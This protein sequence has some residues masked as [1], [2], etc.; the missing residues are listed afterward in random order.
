ML[1]CHANKLLLL[2]LLNLMVFD[3]ILL[4]R[5]HTCESYYTRGRHSN[6]DCFYLAQ[7]YFK[8]PRQ[9]IRENAN[10]ICLFPQDLKNTN[11]IYNDHVSSDMTKKEFRKLCK[12]AWE[13]LHG[14]VV[15]DLSSKKDGGKYRMGLDE[16]YIPN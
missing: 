15:I 12:A 13:R 9:T 3:D 14:F 8:L 11:H 1:L 16:F 6:V 4:E 5:Q 2:L 7:N 10:F